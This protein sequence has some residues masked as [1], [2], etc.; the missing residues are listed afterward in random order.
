[1]IAAVAIA[2][3]LPLYTCNPRDFEHIDGL[4]VV[5]ARGRTLSG[6]NLA[7]L[8]ALISLVVG[9]LISFYAVQFTAL[10]SSV[11]G[12]IHLGLIIDLRMRESN[13]AVD[14]DIDEVAD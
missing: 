8:S 13:T 12:L 11:L 5:L 10:S 14:A 7:L 6:L 3:Q 1:M 9:G 2:N 4:E